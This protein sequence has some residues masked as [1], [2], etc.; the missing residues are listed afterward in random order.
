MPD[1]E[2]ST[3]ATWALPEIDAVDIVYTTEDRFGDVRGFDPDQRFA[4]IVHGEIVG[5]LYPDDAPHETRISLGTL[6]LALI[7]LWEV[8]EDGESVSEVLDSHS[9][10]WVR[11][12][13][14]TERED[15]DVPLPIRYLLIADR[16]EVIPE[17][18]GHG[19]GLHALARAILSWSVGAETL[20]CLIAAS[21]VERREEEDEAKRVADAEVIARYWQRLGFERVDDPDR[22]PLLYGYSVYLD[23]VDTLKRYCDWTPAHQDESS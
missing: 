4:Q 14:L 16:V 8:E 2:T 5:I 6:S 1:Q 21:T 15:D 19:L 10:E 12:L 9:S 18:R 20:V 7:D 17:A 3:T 13:P 22:M 23:F 11:Y